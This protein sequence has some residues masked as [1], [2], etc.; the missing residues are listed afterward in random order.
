MITGGPIAISGSEARPGPSRRR[1]ARRSHPVRA[2]PRSPAPFGGTAP[3]EPPRA[4]QDHR[5][6]RPTRAPAP[7]VR[8]RGMISAWTSSR[9][10]GRR[11]KRPARRS[12]CGSCA[13]GRVSATRCSSPMTT[14]SSASG[15]GVTPGTFPARLPSFAPQP[16]V[17]RCKRCCMRTA[18]DGAIR[19]W[20]WSCVV[21]PG[22]RCLA[23]EAYASPC[24][25]R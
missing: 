23:R 1:H 3:S 8:R 24:W 20:S 25:R 19:Y 12:P 13:S 10:S 9:S 18:P 4:H 7:A 22:S 11:S 5:G 6:T 17:S 2:A 15:R 21:C 16:A 14:S